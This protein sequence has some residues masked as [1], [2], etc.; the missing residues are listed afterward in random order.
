MVSQL[1]Q[2]HPTRPFQ[3][4]TNTSVNSLVGFPAVFMEC[5]RRRK[6]SL[7]GCAF[8]RYTSRSRNWRSSWWRKRYI[9]CWL[10]CHL[11]HVIAIL[12]DGGVLKVTSY[13]IVVLLPI[14]ELSIAAEASDSVRVFV[15][16]VKA[17]SCH[18]RREG[19]YVQRPGV[20]GLNPLAPR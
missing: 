2:Q 5:A 6:C 16:M 19:L 11:I 17:S 18:C 3:R 15:A 20:E 1:P 4:N 10:L 14:R 7:A 9:L 8:V 12:G 13:R